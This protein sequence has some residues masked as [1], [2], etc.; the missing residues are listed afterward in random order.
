MLFDDYERTDCRP[1]LPRE[2]IYALYNRGASEEISAS[3]SLIERWFKNFPNEC[4][5]EELKAR[6]Q[7]GDNENFYSVV[8]ELY[9]ATQLINQGF[10]LDI[11]PNLPNDSERRPDFLVT[12][13]LGEQF[14]IEAS[15]IMNASGL[16][17]NQQIEDF[18]LELDQRP[19]P[20]FMIGI[21]YEGEPAV[22]PSAVQAANYIHRWLDNLNFEVC[23]ET[24]RTAPES[25]PRTEWEDRGLTIKVEALPIRQNQEDIRENRLIGMGSMQGGVLDRKTSLIRKLGK[26]SKRYGE[27]DKPFIIAVQTIDI[28]GR[29]EGDNVDTLYGT[30]TMRAWDRSVYRANDGF[31]Q[32]REQQLSKR[33]VSGVWIVDRLN[34][35]ALENVQSMRYLCPDPTHPVPHSFLHYRHAVL[36][37]DQVEYHGEDFI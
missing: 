35:H 31:W 32:L 7:S 12:D 36:N 24:L 20:N 27:L 5:R 15:V 33:G 11:H 25:L 13:H 22:T 9:L 1:L 37:E 3:R 34:L 23:E 26:K 8:F 30:L 10:Q 17:T 21:S 2:S 4:E 28:P 6:F 16:P 19:H 29:I 18:L 14:Y